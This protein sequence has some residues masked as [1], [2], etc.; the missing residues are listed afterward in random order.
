MSK[1]LLARSPRPMRTRAG[2]P[3]GKLASVLGTPSDL[4]C[5]RLLALLGLRRAANNVHQDVTE[6]TPGGDRDEVAA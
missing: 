4:T 1:P 5:R 2:G 3:R 6:E